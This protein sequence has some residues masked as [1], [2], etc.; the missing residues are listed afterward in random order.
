MYC[1]FWTFLH[2]RLQR[3][4]VALSEQ[5]GCIIEIIALLMMHGMYVFTVLKPDFT[6][7]H[8][9]CSCL[10]IAFA[11]LPWGRLFSK[12]VVI[13]LI[14]TEF[15][16]WRTIEGEGKRA[17]AWA[18]SDVVHCPVLWDIIVTKCLYYGPLIYGP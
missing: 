1:D 8:H 12:C 4:S 10:S 13:W 9:A 11:C 2:K 3:I 18:L 6:L 5:Q 15:S 16:C 17:S 7:L 14:W